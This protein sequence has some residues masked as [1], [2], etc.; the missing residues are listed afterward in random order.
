MREAAT[1]DGA[2]TEH[3]QQRDAGGGVRKDDRQV[4]QSLDHA[5]A[6]E[7]AACEQVG[8]RHAEYG[9]QNGGQQG[10]LD[11]RRQGGADVGLA[12]G[13]QELV[14]SRAGDQRDER[15][16][17]EQQQ[18][19][20]ERPRQDREGGGTAVRSHGLA[21]APPLALPDRAGPRAHGV[22]P[23]FR[24]RHSGRSAAGSAAS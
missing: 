3:E 23:G 2:A 18:D 7:A 10:R 9:G 8:Q 12:E 19:K 13:A 24:G 14:Q 15:R 21:A 4:D 20:A 11:R 17:D 16:C 1:E 6:G 22:C 5:L